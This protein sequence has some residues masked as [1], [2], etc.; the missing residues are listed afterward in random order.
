MDL[1][2]PLR[3]FVRT[4][5]AEVLEV[6][7]QTEQAL[8]ISAIWRLASAGSRQGL[9][10]VL[11]NLVH[12]GLVRSTNIGHSSTYQLNRDHVLSSLILAISRSRTEVVAKIRTAVHALNPRPVYASIFG[13]FARRDADSNSDIDL[14]LLVADSVIPGSDAWSHQMLRLQDQVFAWT[15]NRLE[16]LILTPESLRAGL[17]EPVLRSII[18]DE[19]ALTD[20]SL[21]DFTK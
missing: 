5:E 1:T 4:R 12:Q 18:A 9:Y 3:S 8:T 14:C 2:H 13:S 7:A 6:L 20:N 19:L 11:D 16:P 17:G 10:P 15:G 21:E